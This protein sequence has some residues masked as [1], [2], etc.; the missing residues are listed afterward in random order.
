[1]TRHGHEA[2]AAPPVSPFP[3]DLS[4]RAVV[5]GGLA[6]GAAAGL[7]VGPLGRRFAAAQT[8]GGTLTIAMTAD[9]TTFDPHV[10]SVTRDS[11]YA[12]SLFD[13]LIQRSPDGTLYPGLATEWAVAEDGVTWTFKLRTDVT[14]HDG[15][16]FNA[17][18]V[19]F[20]LDRIVDPAIKSEY[21]VFQIGPYASSRAIDA[22]TVEVTMSRPYGPLPTSLATFGMGMVSPTAVAAAGDQFGF[23]PVGSGPFMFESFTPQSEVVLV[24]NPNYNW[25]GPIDAHTGPAYLERVVFRTI[26]EAATRSAAL[27]SGE[28]DFAFLTAP[29]LLTFEGNTD[30]G[31]QAIALEGYP[32]AGLFINTTKAPTD[33]VLVRKALNFAVDTEEVRTV[34]YENFAEPANSVVSTFAWAYNPASALYGFDPVQAGALLDQAGWVMGDGEYRQKNGVQLDLVFLSLTGVRNVAELV[35][36]QLR[37]VGVNAELL[38]QD[39]PAQQQT[40]QSGGHNLVW[41]Q[42]GGVD[43]A[44]L[45]KVYGSENIGGGWNFSHYSNPDIDQMFLDGE[46]LNDQEQRRE[47]YDQVQMTLMDD[48]TIVPLNNNGSY[49]GYKSSVQGTDVINVSA[50]RLYNVSISQ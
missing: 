2:D 16:P 30:F 25:S 40:A 34:I 35:Q 31:T 4:R 20:N 43:P 18:A 42:W 21:A 9:P 32:P 45:K 19:V 5:K 8:P 44:D 29:D 24:R 10:N 23:Q 11:I 14:F 22:A 27:Q 37:A 6:A 33:D 46:A 28:V 15:T 38:V 47:I 7:A 41:T 1:M 12:Y 50:P 49:L 17:E 26:P 13:N 39:N 36:A 48:A 3:A